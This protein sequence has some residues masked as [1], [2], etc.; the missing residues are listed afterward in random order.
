MNFKLSLALFL[1]VLSI[2]SARADD[3]PQWMGPRRDNIW[4]EEGIIAK[5]PEGGPKVVWRAPVAGGY[6]GPAVANGKVYVTD[7]DAEGAVKQ[8]N[9]Q[10]SEF[11]GNERVLCL[12]E[13]TGKVLWKHEYSVKYDISY[14]AGPRCTPTVHGGKVYTLGSEG[15]LFCLDADTGKVLWS[16][17]FNAEYGAKTAIWGYTGHPLVDGNRLICIVGGE[18]SFAVA[19]DKD[20]GRE[21]WRALTSP[22]QGY[23]PPGILEIAGR[24]QLVLLRPDAVT[25]LDPQTGQEHWSVPYESDS[26]LVVMTP[27]V[28]RDYLF[29][30]GF[31]NRNLLAKLGSDGM[32]AEVEW[33]NNAGHGIS[34]VNVQPFV[35]EG[36]LYG[37]DSDGKLYGVELPSGERL[38]ESTEPLADTGQDARP[39]PRR[40]G[41]A[42]IVRQGDRCWLFTE[43]G[44]LII[45]KFSPDGY[46]ELDRAHILEP[47]N[48]AF[49]RPVVWCAPA[50]ANRRMYV[51]NDKECV[52]VDLAAE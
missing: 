39:R 1:T 46:E 22:E 14:P 32:S 3:W 38:W 36:V 2:S 28:W 29:V 17:D 5:F 42:I 16:K 10:R 35:E 52:A 19:F 15:H 20:T 45:A 13:A 8:A 18:G 48:D 37:F 43:N 44:D 33:R 31:Q 12:D 25:S 34:P 6:A 23:S 40:S 49:G 9:F 4:R 30:G 11:T 21:I 27:V 7:Y 51:R 24:R 41:T 26:N 47:T 50:C